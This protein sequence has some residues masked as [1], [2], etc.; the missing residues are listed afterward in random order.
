MKN[1]FI[2]LL[3]LPLILTIPN[4]TPEYPHQK[5]L[6]QIKVGELFK[7]DDMYMRL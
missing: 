1:F 2:Q 7:Y 4:I 6:K 5:Y 3:D